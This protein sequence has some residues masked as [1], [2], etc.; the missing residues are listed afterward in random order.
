MAEDFFW[1]YKF[2]QTSPESIEF[3]CRYKFIY[4]TEKRVD[5]NDHLGC[6]EPVYMKLN[7][8][9]EYERDQILESPGLYI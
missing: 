6:W 4:R 9:I 5:F 8:E 7:S 3:I 1:T 2:V